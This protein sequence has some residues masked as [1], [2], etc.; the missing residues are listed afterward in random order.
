MRLD[1]LRRSRQLD[2]FY[3]PTQH[4]PTQKRHIGSDVITSCRD[5]KQAGSR[6]ACTEKLEA[7]DVINC[8]NRNVT[9]LPGIFSAP[10]TTRTLNASHNRMEHLPENGFFGCHIERLELSANR[11]R[12][13][14]ALAFWGLE[15]SLQHLNLSFNQLEFVPTSSLRLLRML[16]SL[17]LAGNRIKAVDDN[18]FASLTQLEILS[19][20]SNPIAQFGRH[21]FDGTRLYSLIVDDIYDAHALF[22]SKTHRLIQLKGLSLANNKLARLPSQWMAN[23]TS[24]RYIN[25]MNNELTSLR[26]SSLRGCARSLQTLKLGNNRLSHVPR[27]SLRRITGLKRLQLSGNAI[28]TLPPRAF[29]ASARLEYVDLSNNSIDVISHLAFVGLDRIREVDL[30]SNVLVT[31]DQRWFDSIKNVNNFGVRLSGNPFVCNCMMRWLKKEFRRKSPSSLINI[32]HDLFE[33]KCNRP[34]QF[35]DFPVVRLPMREL[36]CYHNYYYYYYNN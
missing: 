7:I 36:H 12:T 26:A 4:R 24:L 27:S 25:L 32:F 31:L 6:C 17:V 30:R 18:S 13:L 3:N 22:A 1:G 5:V 28:R 14:S 9:S 16:K 20:S 23:L 34:V 29:N 33:I 15:L 21:A 19:I 11:L 10:V 8:A 35:R 2:E